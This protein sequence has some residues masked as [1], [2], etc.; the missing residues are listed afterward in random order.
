MS[1]DGNLLAESVW[2][3]EGDVSE[4]GSERETA[5]Y[6]LKARDGRSDVSEMGS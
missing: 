4:M 5:T 1:M 2:K 3:N 6:T